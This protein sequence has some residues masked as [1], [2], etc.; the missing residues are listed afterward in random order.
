MCK[1]LSYVLKG[2]GY[3]VDTATD[4][5]SALNMM[6]RKQF[7]L[8]LLDYKLSGVQDMTGLWVYEKVKQLKPSV[9]AIM[10]S[11]YGDNKIKTKAREM[12]VKYF[13]DKPFLIR[14]LLSRIKKTLV[15]SDKNN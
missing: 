10:I 1:S 13:L 4:G 7:D 3:G 15:H 2:E 14:Q 6:V 5:N 11:A 12:G 8:V 9:K